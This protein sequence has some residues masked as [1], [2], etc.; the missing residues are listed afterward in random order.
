MDGC[1]TNQGKHKGLKNYYIFENGHHISESCGSHK[2]ALI[3]KNLLLEGQYE[4]LKE[5]DDVAVGLASYFKDSSLRTAILENAQ[6]ILGH[7][8]LK[9]FSPSPTRWLSH[10]DC[11]PRL[12]EILPSVLVA[13]N[14]IYTDKKDMKALGFM[15]S[16]TKSDLLLSCLANIDIYEVLSP[17][18]HWLQT[19]PSMADVTVLGSLVKSTVDKLR[20]LAGDLSKKNLWNEADMAKRKF[21]KDKY[22]E[23]SLIVD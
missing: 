10:K 2:V 6:K 5:T 7:K 18:I 20:F 4:C 16:L 15:L 13:L 12:L 8:V 17:L 21:I 22:V 11:Y 1:A 23:L 9:L 19:S 3:I 14:S